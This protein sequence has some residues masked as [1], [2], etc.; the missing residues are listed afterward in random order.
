[1]A[2]FH[3]MPAPGTFPSL[4]LTPPPRQHNNCLC[5]TFYDAG[6][7][8][9]TFFW[10]NI[11]FHNLLLLQ[12][13]VLICHTAYCMRNRQMAA[14]IIHKTGT[15]HL[16]KLCTRRIFLPYRTF[17]LSA[18]GVVTITF[19]GVMINAP[20]AVAAPLNIF[21]T[22]A[23]NVSTTSPSVTYSATPLIWYPSNDFAS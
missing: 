9:N 2:N 21:S 6:S 4:H 13:I 7:T 14:Y 23:L 5:R 20:F 10:I 8:P 22:I 17:L 19:S 18:P 16:P 11:G 12:R 15:K 3:T 1:M